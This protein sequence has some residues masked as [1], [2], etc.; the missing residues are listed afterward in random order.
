[1]DLF[2]KNDNINERLIIGRL[3]IIS[4]YNSNKNRIKPFL[5]NVPISYSLKTTENL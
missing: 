2:M 1:M 4:Y 3:T 5:T